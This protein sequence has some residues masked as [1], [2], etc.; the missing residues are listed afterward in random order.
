MV[1]AADTNSITWADN[2]T[3]DLWTSANLQITVSSGSEVLVLASFA[4]TS[5]IDSMATGSDS[6][7]AR[8]DREGANIASDCADVNT[9]GSS[10]GGTYNIGSGDPGGIL[11][12]GGT[13]AFV[14]S[15][16]S[17]GGTFTYEMCTSSEA[18][19]LISSNAW[20]KQRADLTLYEVNDAGD[21]A[22]IFPTNDTSIEPGEIV[23]MDTTEELLI[24][25]SVN[26][27]DR[28]MLGVVATRPALV[29]G[30][31][32]GK[33]VT[34]KPVALSGRVPVKVT[35]ENGPIKKGD[36]LTS[37]SKPGIAM[38][39]IK[40]GQIIGVALEDYAGKE[41]G[42]I[43]TFVKTGYF[44][45]TNLKEIL[46]PESATSS[47]DF[48]KK[49]LTQLIKNK[50]IV[51]A[52][53]FEASE[54]LTDRLAAAIEVISPRGIFDGLEVNTIGAM[55]DKTRF[56]ADTI[57]IGRPYM[58]K[59]TAGFAVIRA[60]ERRVTIEFD[61]E[62]LTQPVVNTTI[63]LDTTE[64]GTID[65]AENIL[66]S[67]VKYII[68]NKNVKGFSILLNIPAVQDI[69]FSWTAF[70]VQDAKTVF[71]GQPQTPLALPAPPIT[72]A[73][74]VNI[75]NEQPANI[76]ITAPPAPTSTVSIPNAPPLSA[77]V[78]EVLPTMPIPTPVLIPEATPPPVPVEPTT[79]YE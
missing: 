24:K 17:G 39:A 2:D 19:I 58:N 51:P 53:P 67:G 7:G 25:R 79:P 46:T 6:I 31:R 73:S 65:T 12:I 54:I 42:T 61:R 66:G 76:S 72:P 37:S 50:A 18:T 13:T 11:A 26:A 68:A 10:F 5:D 56:M 27:Y 14:D 64:G 36:S 44:T 35:T 38:K 3:T 55:G 60:G 34:G 52:A 48:G 29:I 28:R 15:G 62:Y 1:T 22:E 49:I 43:L 16:T 71:S 47:E 32:E 77:S 33:G 9:V 57:F 78:V 69:P 21:L 74:V 63:A 40:T 30:G 45:G 41:T 23:S 20:A 4:A 8:I 59:D 70:A 75:P